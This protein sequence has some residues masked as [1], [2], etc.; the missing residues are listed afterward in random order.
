MD[1]QIR[2]HAP[3][4][5]VVKGTDTEIV[6]ELDGGMLVICALLIAIGSQ[7]LCIALPA[8]LAG[9]AD[10]AHKH[11]LCCGL[12]TNVRSQFAAAFPLAIRGKRMF[13][14]LSSRSGILFFSPRHQPLPMGLTSSSPA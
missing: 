2:L 4:A 11:M 5:L 10:W 6:A 8:S 7:E 1:S 14:I 13:C 3:Q 12:A 9:K